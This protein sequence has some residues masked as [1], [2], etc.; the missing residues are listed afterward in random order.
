MRRMMHVTQTR[1]VGRRVGLNV[2]RVIEAGVG[3]RRMFAMAL[4]FCR[5]DCCFSRS[6]RSDGKVSDAMKR[7][8]TRNGGS[9]K[10]RVTK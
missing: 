3:G 9:V 7:D 2:C 5:C 8:G 6:V 1:Q 10:N 4:H